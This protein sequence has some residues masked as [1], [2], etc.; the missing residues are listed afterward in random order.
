V[1]PSIQV[2]GKVIKGWVGVPST[3]TMEVKEGLVCP[4]NSG[5]AEKVAPVSRRSETGLPSMMAIPLG[6]REVMVVRPGSPGLHQSS[7]TVA[8]PKRSVREERGWEG[9]RPSAL[10]VG[11]AVH[12]PVARLHLGHWPGGRHGLGHAWAQCPS[13]PH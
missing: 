5:K 3:L 2:K 7:A 13:R 1:S 6:S 4:Q 11:G 12:R 10:R 8:S 9:L